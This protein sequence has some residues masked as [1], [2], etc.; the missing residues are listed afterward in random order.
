MAATQFL[1]Y[2]SATVSLAFC[3]HLGKQVLDGVS[4]AIT[5]I[6]VLGMSVMLGLSSACDTLFSQTFGSKHKKK[7]GVIFQKSVLILLLCSLPCMALYVNA[8]HL[9]LLFGQEPAIAKYSGLYVKTF[10]F[11]LPAF[12]IE[13]SLF[14]YLQSQSIVRPSLIIGV[15]TNILNAGMHGLSVYLWEFGIKGA[16]VS[17]ILTHWLIVIFHIIYIYTSNV[18]VATW[19]GFSFECLQDWYVF[20]RYALP[21]LA[22]ICLE[23]WGI[24]ILT[25]IAGLLGETQLGAHTIT[26]NI[27]AIGFTI[28]SGIAVAACVRVGNH[29][30]AQNPVGAM[31]ASRVTLTIAISFALSMFLVIQIL[32]DYIPRIFSSDTEVVELASELLLFSSFVGLLDITQGVA[33]GII[34]GMGHQAFGAGVNVTIYVLIGTPLSICLMLLTVLNVRGAWVGICI[35]AGLQA[36]TYLTKILL[37]DWENEASRA[38]K[39]TDGDVS[40]VR[41][42]VTFEIQETVNSGKTDLKIT[43]GIVL[44]RI[45]TFAVFLLLLAG[46]ILLDWYLSSLQEQNGFGTYTN[47]SLINSTETNMSTV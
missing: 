24:E 1:S 4:L 27:G 6:G 23:W 20:F 38:R 47:T 33:S 3:G 11:G 44:K 10:T 9:L 15:I 43:R 40:Q 29:L 30:G 2:L 32:R 37:T 25:F 36:M 19:S 45:C 26:I 46:G 16:A 31:T 13:F 8:E 12:A 39:V 5:I 34:R 41:E 18:Y 21:G 7:V 35:C 22:M 42:D 14:K 28:G 17:L